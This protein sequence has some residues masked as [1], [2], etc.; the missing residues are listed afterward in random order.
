MKKHRYEIKI[1]WTG[2]QGEG[3]RDYKSYNRNHE[4]SGQEKYKEILASSDPSFLGD[5][6]RYNPEELFLSSISSCHMLW[7]LH[8]CAVNK[9]VITNYVDY[10]TGIMEEEEG[11]SGKFKEVTLHPEI[12]IKNKGFIKKAESLHSEANRLCF[13]ANSCNFKIHHQVKINLQKS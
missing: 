1:E 3:T 4:I 2:N 10:A 13:I 8:L 5:S 6:S 9:I 7:Y 12:T 11:G